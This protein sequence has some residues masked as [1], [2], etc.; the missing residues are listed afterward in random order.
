MSMPEEALNEENVQP[1]QEDVG[2]Q[3]AEVAVPQPKDVKDEFPLTSEAVDPVVETH[4]AEL[5]APTPDVQARV[6]RMEQWGRGLYPPNQLKPED[7]LTADAV[8]QKLDT[9]VDNEATRKE[10]FVQLLHE[11]AQKE[12]KA[13]GAQEMKMV[14]TQFDED[15]T[16]F[17][18]Q[19]LEAKALPAQLSP[20]DLL[21]FG[22]TQEEIDGFGSMDSDDIKGLIKDRVKFADFSR[23]MVE[24]TLIKTD[25]AAK[26]EDALKSTDATA[27]QP[28]SEQG[29]SGRSSLMELAGLN[30]EE[31]KQKIKSLLDSL[32]SEASY[33]FFD[34]KQNNL[35][36]FLD[37]FF[38]TNW[39]DRS[40]YGAYDR[41]DKNMEKSGQQIGALTIKESLGGESQSTESLVSL[42]KAV[43][44]ELGATGPFGAGG[45]DYKAKL[46]L[47]QEEFRAYIT[48][49]EGTDAWLQVFSG[50][51]KSKALSRLSAWVSGVS[52]D[53]EYRASKSQLEP[54][55]KD[56]LQKN[57]PKEGNY[58]MTQEAL[59]Y[60]F[61]R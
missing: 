39:R 52:G 36:A 41:V 10:G 28:Q 23:Y 32:A 51:N 34:N 25:V 35:E 40:G 5:N 54:A 22:F 37:A 4:A 24:Q 18:D 26:V 1:T 27:S 43:I 31:K 6:D 17:V 53:T 15:L 42:Q 21:Q 61:T 20:K 30:L 60:L 47:G 58:G 19:Q 49:K 48:S 56:A 44:A 3:P 16:A 12:G 59:A 45:K 50:E 8:R 13:P 55:K 57:L 2:E 29:N 9:F 11:K 38:D 7:A 33:Q 14:V 46:A